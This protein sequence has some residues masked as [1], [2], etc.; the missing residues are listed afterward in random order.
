[1][2]FLNMVFGVPGDS[3]LMATVQEC[4]NWG[5]ALVP[6]RTAILL[7]LSSE[8]YNTSIGWLGGYRETPHLDSFPGPRLDSQTE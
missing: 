2:S 8:E 3:E 4:S 6:C 5:L 1:M 7:G